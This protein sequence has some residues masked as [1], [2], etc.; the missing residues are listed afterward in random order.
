[1][2]AMPGWNRC[3]TVTAAPDVKTAAISASA[4]NENS[5][6][7]G[8]H[9]LRWHPPD[10]SFCQAA[11]GGQWRDALRRAGRTP[12]TKSIGRTAGQLHLAAIDAGRWAGVL[13][14]TGT[15]QPLDPAT[16]GG[17]NGRCTRYCGRRTFAR[18]SAS[19][20]R[21]LYSSNSQYR[22]GADDRHGIRVTR[23]CTARSPGRA[24]NA[25]IRNRHDRPVARIN[26][27]HRTAAIAPATCRR[28]HID[29]SITRKQLLGSVACGTVTLLIQACGG[30][31]ESAFLA[32]FGGGTNGE[33]T[34]D[35]PEPVSACGSSGSEI[36]SNHGHVLTVPTAD[37]TSITAMT[38]SILGSATHDHVLT[39]LPDDLAQ[40][41][42]GGTLTVTSSLTDAPTFGLH[43]HG[44]TVTC[45]RG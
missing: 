34:N 41:N 43:S 21:L 24:E 45:V 28:S 20:R 22:P 7:V 38:Y 9:P 4:A 10:A 26:P 15:K 13:T 16:G 30:G 35:D 11:A 33:D 3:T 6:L 12:R 31:G 2:P 8:L 42:F 23:G 5:Q 14:L 18:R 1:M 44:V 17:S 29:M 40:L 39:L 36:T 25:L 19:R 37:L 27:Q 32:L